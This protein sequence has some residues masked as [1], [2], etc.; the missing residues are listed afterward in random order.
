[1]ENTI[2]V[3]PEQKAV[4]KSRELLTF[5]LGSEKLMSSQDME[6][7]DSAEEMAA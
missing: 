2:Q 5:T 6:L 3:S 4:G 7:I 1:M